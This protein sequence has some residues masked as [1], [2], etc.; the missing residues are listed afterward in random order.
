MSDPLEQGMTLIEL[1]LLAGIVG[2][3]IWVALQLQDAFGN[4]GS[5]GDPLGIKKAANKGGLDISAGIRQAASGGAPSAPSDETMKRFGLQDPPFVL[6]DLLPAWVN[7]E[8]YDIEPETVDHYP[9]GEGI[10]QTW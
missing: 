4:N 5:D 10:T 6:T 7:T 2:A 1:L 8:T 9:D 3:I